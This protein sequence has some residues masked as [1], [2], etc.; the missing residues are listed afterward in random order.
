[1]RVRIATPP[2]WPTGTPSGPGR[3]DPPAVR[4]AVAWSPADLAPPD[5]WICQTMPEDPAPGLPGRI[6]G[7]A[8]FRTRAAGRRAGARASG[9]LWNRF[10]PTVSRY[11]ARYY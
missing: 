10:G 4:R 3:Y 8:R 11:H 2:W 9:F 5:D 7:S 1:M 6:V